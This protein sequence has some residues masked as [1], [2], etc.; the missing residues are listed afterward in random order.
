MLESESELSFREFVETFLSFKSNSF[1]HLR[2]VS[3][4]KIYFT[5][6]K[7]FGKEIFDLK[8]KNL[9]HILL[10]VQLKC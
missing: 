6:K 8:K 2:K 4:Q 5:E 7:F 10:P 1:F 9:F 3:V